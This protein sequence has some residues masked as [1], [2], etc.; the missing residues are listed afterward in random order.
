MGVAV[1]EDCDESSCQWRDGQLDC[2]GQSGCEVTGMTCHSECDPCHQ[3]FLLLCCYAFAMTF[4]VVLVSGGMFHD[5][6]NVDIWTTWSSAAFQR[7]SS[8]IRPLRHWSSLPVGT[9]SVVLLPGPSMLYVCCKN[10]QQGFFETKDLH[11]KN[12]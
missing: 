2:D 8:D 9:E 1:G 10:G 7:R 6:R 3:Q 11:K 5:V 12:S 4:E